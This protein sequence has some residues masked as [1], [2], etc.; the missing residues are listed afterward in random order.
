MSNLYAQLARLAAANDLVVSREQL[1][2][3]G[4]TDHQIKG[5]L[6]KG[7]WQQLQRGVYL[8]SAARPTWRQRA[9]AA[10]LAAGRDSA[11]AAASGLLWWG[12]DGAPEGTIELIVPRTDGPTPRGVKVHR[13]TREVKVRVRDGVRVTGIED[14]V[15]DFAACGDRRRV[16]LAVESALLSRRT[17]E[18]RI[19]RHIA[20]NSRPGVRGVALL[21]HVMAHRPKG[22]PGRSYLELEVLDLIR[23][24]DL[25]V[26]TRNVDVIDADGKK[27]EIDLCYVEQMGAIAADGKAFH[28]TA[29]QTKADRKRQAALE[30]VGF[31]F[32]RFTWADVF[33][34]PDWALEQIRGL[35][36]GVVPS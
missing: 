10:F 17:T 34:R 29:T 19:W 31:R 1:L 33:D 27:R 25:P 15:L 20:T 35:L 18:R 13:P 26:P 22:K 2:G 21:R 30:A 8:L 16:E 11:L 6:K 12:L 7:L 5:F 9:R 14:T 36:G 32:V 24:S 4:L 3:I 28:S 23:A